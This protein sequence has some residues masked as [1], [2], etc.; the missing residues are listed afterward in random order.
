MK[1]AIQ[2][3]LWQGPRAIR[4]FRWEG[5]SSMQFSDIVSGLNQCDLEGHFNDAFRKVLHSE[6]KDGKLMV[7]VRC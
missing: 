6:S 4:N 2:A 5:G 1:S 3:W 7:V